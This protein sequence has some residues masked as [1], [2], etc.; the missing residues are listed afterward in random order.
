MEEILRN[1]QVGMSRLRS[2]FRDA[3]LTYDD[4]DDGIIRVKENGV[5]ILVEIDEEKELVSLASMWSFAPQVGDARRLQIVNT[6]NDTL[7]LVRFSVTS[8]GHMWCD[9]HLPYEEGIIVRALIQ[10]LKRF[11]KI[12]RGAV[13]LNEDEFA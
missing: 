11:A 3:Y 1:N 10:S 13:A 2:I 8:Q 9:L 5:T 6:L 12:S 4:F 7:I